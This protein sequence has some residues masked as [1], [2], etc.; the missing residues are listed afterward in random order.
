VLAG[1]VAQVAAAIRDKTDGGAHVSVDAL[2]SPETCFN[3]ISCLR[4]RGRHIQV[5][6]MK[7]GEHQV[8]I[9]IDQVIAGELEILGSHGMPA[10]RYDF[11]LDMI[12]EGRL[13]PERLIG[14][15]IPLSDLPGEL[16]AMD[17]FQGA[18]MAVID[19]FRS[20]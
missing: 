7:A 20:G 15:T 13:Q 17:R 19:R 14:R 16:V 12:V 8:R 2:G 9:P 5:G 18:G 3:S 10:H 4:K 11:M 1:N 6:I